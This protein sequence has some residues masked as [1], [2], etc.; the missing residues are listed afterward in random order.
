MNWSILN[1][2]LDNKW[3]Y[4]IHILSNSHVDCD[5]QR[6]LMSKRCFRSTSTAIDDNYQQQFV[7]F[8]MRNQ[9]KAL[10]FKNVFSRYGRARW[11][12]RIGFWK[13][14]QFWW[15]RKGKQID[16]E[17]LLILLW[18]YWQCL[19]NLLEWQRSNCLSR[20]GARIRRRNPCIL[21][22]K[23]GECTRSN[24]SIQTIATAITSW[25]VRSNVR[26]AENVR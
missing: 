2:S 1:S 17:N 11:G 6:A 5:W 24:W 22:D 4:R 12:H 19:W 20:R 10:R 18:K 3:M 15:Q 9:N 23:A 26:V 8:H 21:N 13:W 14:N 7:A 25:T 16:E